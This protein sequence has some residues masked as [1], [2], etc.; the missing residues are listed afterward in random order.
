MS[1]VST[2]VGA[3]LDAL[4][5]FFGLR[6]PWGWGSALAVVLLVVLF[7]GGTTTGGGGGGGGGE[8]FWRS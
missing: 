6:C 5:R 2:V 3:R 8:G 7:S 4:D 1:V